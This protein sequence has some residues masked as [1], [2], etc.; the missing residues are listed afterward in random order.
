MRR[1]PSIGRN[2]ARTTPG[3]WNE[4]V[5]NNAYGTKSGGGRILQT[6]P[7]LPANCRVLNHLCLR[8]LANNILLVSPLRL[9]YKLAHEVRLF[10]VAR[11]ESSTSGWSCRTNA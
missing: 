3:R 2:I 9:G 7:W 4:I 10:Q 5:G 6:T 8:I 11:M 1:T